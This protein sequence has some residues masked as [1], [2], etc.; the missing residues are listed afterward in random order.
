[1]DAAEWPK[2]IQRMASHV[3]LT[4]LRLTGGKLAEGTSR[5]ILKMLSRLLGTVLEGD[6][7]E[8]LKS[9]ALEAVLFLG[10][11]STSSETTLTMRKTAKDDLDEAR[12]PEYVKSA[13]Q[14][15]LSCASIT[16]HDELVSFL[17]VALMFAC[18]ILVAH[19]DDIAERPPLSYSAPAPARKAL[20]LCEAL[21]MDDRLTKLQRDELITLLLKNPNPHIRSV[22]ITVLR[23]HTTG[24]KA[25]IDN[26]LPDFGNHLFNHSISHNDLVDERSHAWLV[27]LLN[28]VYMLN[29]RL[30]QAKISPQAT[31]IVQQQFMELL[32]SELESASKVEARIDGEEGEADALRSLMQ[33]EILRDAWQKAYESTK[34]S[35]LS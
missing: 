25:S 5:D 33:L 27:S 18:Q 14:V 34:T 26:L 9:L 4:A 19:F 10:R 2:Q 3:I 23:K 29:T 8:L 20:D 31:P 21:V 16:S 7:D 15:S 32:R 6:V 1:M 24:T 11:A 12:L 13:L 30:A 28:F 35:S 22:G 17:H